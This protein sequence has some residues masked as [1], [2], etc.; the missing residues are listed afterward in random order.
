MVVGTENAISTPMETI[1][2]AKAL[3]FCLLPAG[4][5]LLAS[6]VGLAWRMSPTVVAA[7][8]HC[9]AGVVIAAVSL[10]IGPL[11]INTFALGVANACAVVFGCTLSFIVFVP[12]CLYT[13]R[14]QAALDRSVVG[15]QSFLRHLPW[16]LLSL[17]AMG[18]FL[19]GLILSMSLGADQTV[20]MVVAVAFA[21]ETAVLGLVTSVTLLNLQYTR[22]LAFVAAVCLVCVLLFGA[23]LG[24]LVGQA[25]NV[26]LHLAIL[27][28]ATGAFL[29]LVLD[30]LLIEAR[31]QVD[32]SWQTRPLLH[33]GFLVVLVFHVS[34]N[35]Q[36]KE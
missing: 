17:L 31:E 3:L 25:Q 33:V 32:K 12:L 4:C 2:V 14:S 19:D 5:Q 28:F 20:G 22:W 7:L 6:L 13:S 24:A 11:L 29:V 26:A 27:S 30:S 36:S 1:S 15:W 9:S 34:L 10:E 16:P 21:V 18:I 23:V 8:Q 35:Q